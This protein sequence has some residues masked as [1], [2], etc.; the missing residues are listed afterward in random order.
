MPLKVRYNISVVIPP[1]IV[2]FYLLMS[3]PTFPQ[4]PINHVVNFENTSL[5][6]AP[7]HISYAV[8]NRASRAFMIK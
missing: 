8:E 5:T 3:P 7:I 4:L 2:E 1:C 6:L